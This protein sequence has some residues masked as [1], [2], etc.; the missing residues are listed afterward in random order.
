MGLRIKGRI[1]RAGAGIEGGGVVAEC[2][3]PFGVWQLC[4]RYR[5]LQPMLPGMGRIASKVANRNEAAP[6]FMREVA[7]REPV[8]LA[9]FSHHRE[10][11]ALVLLGVKDCIT[12]VQRE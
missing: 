11:M 5:R 6:H 3:S 1:K 8:D 7:A 4:N 10:L 2:V 12:V 9:N